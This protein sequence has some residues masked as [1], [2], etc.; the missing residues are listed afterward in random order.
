MSNG[1][2]Y[3]TVLAAENGA[4]G[5]C[6]VVEYENALWIVPEW[7]AGPDARS[8]KPERMIRLDQFPFQRFDPP[9]DVGKFRRVSFALNAPVPKVL[10]L[11]ELSSHTKARYVVLDRPDVMYRW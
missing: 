9:V 10:L 8:A 5:E 6:S 4:M 2:V 1:R 7:I 11:D 3:K